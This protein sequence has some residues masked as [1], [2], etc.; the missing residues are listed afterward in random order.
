MIRLIDIHEINSINL[1]L[2]RIRRKNELNI[3]F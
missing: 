3:I 1:S 2:K